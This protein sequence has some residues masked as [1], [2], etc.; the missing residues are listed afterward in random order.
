MILAQ[1]AV[2]CVELS[3]QK[4]YPHSKTNKKGYIIKTN[5]TNSNLPSTGISKQTQGFDRLQPTC[6]SPTSS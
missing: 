6:L 2:Y 4:E 1:R 5:I 3:G